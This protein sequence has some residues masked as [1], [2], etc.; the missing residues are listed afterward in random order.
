M[1]NIFGRDFDFKVVPA[2]NKRLQLD[3]T[4]IW[5]NTHFGTQVVAGDL[6][7]LDNDAYRDMTNPR[8]GRSRRVLVTTSVGKAPYWPADEVYDAVKAEEDRE[9]E[10]FEKG[11]IPRD[12]ARYAFAIFADGRL[13]YFDADL[14]LDVLQSFGNKEVYFTTSRSKLGDLMIWNPETNHFVWLMGADSNRMN[15]LHTGPTDRIAIMHM[16]DAEF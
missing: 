10:M 1:T 9:G 16:G 3:G 4:V 6:R 15:E 11:G 5:E 14:M 2:P 13:L 7:S 12:Q 8:N